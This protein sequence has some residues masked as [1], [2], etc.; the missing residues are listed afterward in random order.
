MKEMLTKAVNKKSTV[1]NPVSVLLETFEEG[2]HSELLR[3]EWKPGTYAHSAEHGYKIYVV[4]QIT[5]PGLKTLQE[6]RG[7]YI[8]DY[9]NELE[10]ELN[11]RL[12]RKYNVKIHQDVVDETPY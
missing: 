7:Y 3:N 2:R 12:R 6:A 11:D 4:E 9:Q 5:N 8:T 10:K 1:S